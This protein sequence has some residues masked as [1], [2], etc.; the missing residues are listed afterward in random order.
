MK[1]HQREMN[2]IDNSGQLSFKPF[3]TVRDA[4][5]KQIKKET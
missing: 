2:L 3:G 4:A 5:N 1:H